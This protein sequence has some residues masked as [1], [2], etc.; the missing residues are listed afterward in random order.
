MQ[1]F[2]EFEEQ[3]HDDGYDGGEHHALYGE[4]TEGNFGTGQADNHDNRGH[5]EVGGFAVIHLAFYQHADAGGCDYAEQQHADAAHNGHGDTVDKLAELAAEGEDDGHNGCAADNPGAINLGDGHN[6]DIFA[7]GGVRGCSCK[8]ADD[9]GKAVGEQGARKAGVFDEVTVDDVAGYDK[10][11]DVLCEHDEGCRGDNHNR[12]D[13]KDGCVEMRHLEPRRIHDG[14]EVDHTH[15][16]GEDITADNAEENR[17][18]AQKA[19][20][21]DGADDADGEREHGNGDVGG[22]DVVACKAGHVGSDRG[23]LE[24]D[25]GDDGTHGGRR[26]DYINPFRA[27]VVDND[28]KEHEDQAENDEA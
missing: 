14:L 16:C 12:A 8:A 21:G 4:G 17:N 24:A 13:I 27:Y 25:D 22:V 7:V 2:K 9:V 6:A 5:D 1:V 23:K 15:E 19:A 3:A 20:E 26:E 10:V 28:G 11:A 18:N